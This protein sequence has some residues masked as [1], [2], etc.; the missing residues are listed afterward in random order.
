MS[1]HIDIFDDKY[2]LVGSS[3]KKEAHEKGYWHRVFTCIVV[4][5]IEKTIILQKK[6][7]GKYSF[8]RPDYIDIS[9]GGHYK[10]GES[11]QDGVRELNEEMGLNVKYEELVYLG[12]RQNS[13]I[14]GD[15][16]INNEFQ[17]IHLLESR[18]PLIEYKLNDEVNGFVSINI[19]LGLKLLQNIIKEAPVNHV[20]LKDGK[21]IEST[22][23]VSLSDFVPNYLKTDKIFLR[24]FIAAKKYI[25]EKE[26][27]EYPL[28]W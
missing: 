27:K 12:I 11:I 2:N 21:K 14:L 6:I 18:I 3:T 22:V 15:N 20:Y 7:P 23:S 10:K 24:L 9:V 28:F 5:P 25:E 17:E 8:D 1:E 26:S 13:V 19:D 4:N 16:Y